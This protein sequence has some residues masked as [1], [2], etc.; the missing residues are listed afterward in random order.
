METRRK[1][2]NANC[3]APR[4]V[5]HFPRVLHIRIISFLAIFRTPEKFPMKMA[6]KIPMKMAAKIKRMVMGY[7]FLTSALHRKRTDK[8]VGGK[9]FLT[10]ALLCT[11]TD[12]ETAPMAC[13]LKCNP[14]QGAAGFSAKL[15]LSLRLWRYGMLSALLHSTMAS[16]ALKCATVQS[17][18]SSSA[19]ETVARYVVM[20]AV[21]PPRALGLRPSRWGAGSLNSPRLK[22][23]LTI[24]HIIRP[25][26]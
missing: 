17:P 25:L 26:A 7:R 10:S 3:A 24:G 19:M 13:R 23:G 2:E 22:W 6:E 16:Y 4:V 14:N 1:Y 9:A 21:G 20:S 5:S 11:R 12:K 8:M 15:C 18:S